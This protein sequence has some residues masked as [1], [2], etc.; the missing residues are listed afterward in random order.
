MKSKSPNGFAFDVLP[1]D[2]LWKNKISKNITLK[3]M[4]HNFITPHIGNT[5]ESRIKT[6]F[7]IKKFL[8]KLRKN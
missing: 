1:S 8:Q 2:V 7:I 6:N 4:N 5:I 3:K